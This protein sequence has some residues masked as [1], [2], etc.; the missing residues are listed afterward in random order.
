[1]RSQR[2]SGREAK[3]SVKGNM[4]MIRVDGLTKQY[5]GTTVLNIP[6]L[7]IPSGQSFGLVGNNGAGKTTF[8]SLVLDLIRPTTGS[9]SS[10]D[11][12]VEESE[13]WKEYT[14]SYLDDRNLITFLT[15]E[16][17]L[18]FVGSLHG[19]DGRQLTEFYDGLG[20]FF[21]GEV[22]GVH[23]YVRDLS[24]GNQKKVGIAAS[25]IGE[26][27]VL[28][29]DEPFPHLDPS[30]AIRLKRILQDLHQKR[31]VTMLISS[32]DLNHITEVCERIVVLEKGNI[33]RD[34]K[35]DDRTLETLRSYFSA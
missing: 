4:A 13:H 31:N 1:M 16:E 20:Q 18:A 17:Y 25:L 26:P 3:P 28:V 23:K 22:L 32:H 34:L 19:Y 29:L 9:V 35:T 11:K 30:S 12:Q 5:N 2:G 33:V 27:T 8:F 6:A 15:P 7:E 10:N 24:S 21:H 14:G